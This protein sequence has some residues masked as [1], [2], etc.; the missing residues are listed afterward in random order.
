MGASATG[1]R[2][3]SLVKLDFFDSD[4]SLAAFFTR[5]E[6]VIK[7]IIELNFGT[8]R[9]NG[10]GAA[11][12]GFCYS[13]A[14]SCF[15]AIPLSP[16]C[17]A[18]GFGSQRG[19]FYNIS[20]GRG[21]F[22][23]GS[24]ERLRGRFHIRGNFRGRCRGDRRSHGIFF[25]N[26]SNIFPNLSGNDFGIFFGTIFAADFHSH[27]RKALVKSI[28]ILVEH[29]TVRALKETRSNEWN[30]LISFLEGESAPNRATAI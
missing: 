8:W 14:W 18:S 22:S 13:A 1:L 29:A 28:I 23:T 2:S 10:F 17:Y 27:P 9:F 16:S 3:F 11:S 12:W 26:G 24:R 6:A 19:F 4:L 21:R 5:K 20:E 15:F 7:S 25:K 30:P